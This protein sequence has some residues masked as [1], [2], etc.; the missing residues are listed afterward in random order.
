M[1][2][3]M[4]HIYKSFGGFC[5]SNDVSFGV[6]QGRLSALL[7]PSGSGKT[8]ILRML[9]G[10]DHPDSGDICINGLRVNQVEAAQRGVGFVFQNYALFRYMTVFDNIAFGLEV[11]KWPRQ[12]IRSRVGELLS[13]IGLESLGR[14]FPNQLSG[15]QRQRVA[16]ARALAPNPRLLL[17]DEPFAAID[18]KLRQELRS[19]LREMIL[20]VGVTSI[21]VTHD[22]EEA[23][24]VADCI[25]VTNQGRVEQCG[26]PAEIYSQPRTAFVAQFLGQ[27]SQVER[28]DLLAGYEGCGPR[29]ALVRP[30]NVAVSSLDEAPSQGDMATVRLASFR[31][32]Y[33]QLELD[34]DQGPRLLALRQPH[35]RPLAAG[36]RVR[37]RV[38]ELFAL[39]GAEVERLCRP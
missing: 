29:P 39:E 3:E 12:E 30:E 31:G 37:V 27:S 10:L 23:M 14:R 18:A 38:R 20:Q 5:A 26:A 1:Y 2:V 7:G 32:G 34:L 21:F 8:T 28:A 15:G 9:A 17:L 25:I 24:E 16:F 11:Q 22:Q 36:Q 33:T 35:Q 19:W 6:E 13:L 4:K